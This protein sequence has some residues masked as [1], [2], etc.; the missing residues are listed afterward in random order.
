MSAASYAERL[1]TLLGVPPITPFTDPTYVDDAT[2]WL[3]SGCAALG[4]RPDAPVAT[5]AR[6]ALLAFHA[7][8]PQAELPDSR[9]LSERSVLGGLVREAT[10]L[11]EC[12]DGWVAISLPREDDVA[13]VPALVEAAADDDDPWTAVEKWARDQS[14]AAAADRAQLLGI[15][16]AA[17]AHPVVESPYALAA[18][19]GAPTVGTPPL[20]VDL[21]SLWAGPTCARLLGSSKSR[22]RI[23]RTVRG[24]DRPSS[25]AG[26]I[27][28]T[29]RASSTS[30]PPT[31]W[32]SCATCSK[33]P[34]LS[35]RR[36]ARAR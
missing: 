35:S 36:H 22:A 2:E 29:S 10:R 15:A 11:L 34:T 28:A 21:S 7:L 20:V 27:T 4:P 33:K 19:E 23:G 16:A 24:W 25:T 14:S 13:A 5:A 3:A 17:L 9:V 31:V 32:P 30:A 8:A 1:L 18:L 6:G 12:R 26:S